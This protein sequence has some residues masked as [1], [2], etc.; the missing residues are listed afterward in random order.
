MNKSQIKQ[1]AGFYENELVN[2]FLAF[3]LPRCVDSECGGFV[4]CFDNRG[5][6]LVSYD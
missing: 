5:E 4:N 6:K 2:K 1:L 3:W